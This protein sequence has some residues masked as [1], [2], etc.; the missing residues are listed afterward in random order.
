MSY[1]HE[2][3]LI[4]IVK[5]FGLHYVHRLEQRNL[6]EWLLDSDPRIRSKCNSFLRMNRSLSREE[7]THQ[8]DILAWGENHWGALAIEQKSVE[9]LHKVLEIGDDIVLK[10]IGPDAVHSYPDS[11]RDLWL[12]CCG[13][14]YLGSMFCAINGMQRDVIPVGAVDYQLRVQERDVD[15]AYYRNV[16][17]VNTNK[18]EWFLGEYFANP[19]WIRRI[20]KN[21]PRLAVPGYFGDDVTMVNGGFHG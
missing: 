5:R 3:R 4:D 14:S 9:G 12:Q 15:W 16:F 1:E 2:L 6:N 8:I 11:G 19:R 17:F 10:A 13:E 21:N 7:L 18:F 20:R